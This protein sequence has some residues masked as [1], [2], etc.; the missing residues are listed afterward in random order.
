MTISILTNI[1]KYEDIIDT[2]NGFLASRNPSVADVEN[3][4]K[5]LSLL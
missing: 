5:G 3:N 4:H 1:H 2:E